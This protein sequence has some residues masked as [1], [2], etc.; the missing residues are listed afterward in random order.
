MSSL[1]IYAIGFALIIASLARGAHQMGSPPIWTGVG[2]VVSL[3]IG[4]VTGVS[5]SR[6]K[7]D[8]AA[9]D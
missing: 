2:S 6:E 4:L 8:T 5:E 9:S 3:G 1:A 7:D